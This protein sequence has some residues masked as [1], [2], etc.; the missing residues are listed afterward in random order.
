VPKYLPQGP[1]E[2]AGRGYNPETS[3]GEMSMKRIGG[4]LALLT[5]LLM[6]LA[7]SQAGSPKTQTFRVSGNVVGRNPQGVKP[8]TKIKLN[9]QTKGTKSVSTA[10]KADGSFVFEAAASGVYL[11]E[12]GPSPDK[13]LRAL[14]VGSRDLSNIAVPAS[15][16]TFE[17]TGA[18]PTVQE[19]TS[20]L[21]PGKYLSHSAFVPSI[22]LEDTDAGKRSLALLPRL[23]SQPDGYF[24]PKTRFGDKLSGK[25]E[26]RFRDVPAGEYS[27]NLMIG[28]SDVCCLP[29]PTGVLVTVRDR[30]VTLGATR[31]KG[32]LIP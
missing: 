28:E 15:I 27:V 9:A 29:I 4:V 31:L 26:F 19:I 16:P 1:E 20:L 25:G 5:A 8:A 21:P 30:N 17:V 23:Q 10:I 13:G 6:L 12:L 7:T 22:V 11:I 2:Y 14:R 18:M 32:P 3:K 24:E